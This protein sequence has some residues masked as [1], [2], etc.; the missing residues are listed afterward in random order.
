MGRPHGDIVR[1]T[2]ECPERVELLER[3]RVG[4]VVPKQVG[5]PDAADEQGSAGQDRDGNPVRR[6]RLEV[7]DLPGEVLGRMAGGR[8]C[9]Q[10]DAAELDLVVRVDGLVVE[11]IATARGCV[12][13]CPIGRGELERTRQVVVVDMGLDDR[14]QPPAPAVDDLAD[15]P[16]VPWRIDDQRLPV[17]GQDVGRIAQAPSAQDLDIHSALIIGH[18]VQ[19]ARAIG[20]YLHHHGS[21]AVPERSQG[22]ARIG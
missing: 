9:P 20:R 1:E 14:P 2:G 22:D 12:D 10:S 15:P 7:V 6:R 5:P 18:N 16:R 17:G 11:R 13:R 4:R 19:R 21:S 8:P 3:E